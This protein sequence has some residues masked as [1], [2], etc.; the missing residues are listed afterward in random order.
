MY[1]V[2][3]TPDKQAL[4]DVMIMLCIRPA[5]IKNLRIANRGVT[6]YAKNWGQ[7]DIPWVFRSLEKNEERARQ[8]LTWIQ[9]AI[10][11][12][13]LKDLEKPGSTYLSS[14]LKKDEYI[15]KPYEPLLPSSLRKLGLVFAG[16]THMPKNLSK[17]NTYAREA[18]QHSSDNHVSSFDRYIIVNYKKWDQ[19]YD[20]ASP[21][22][23][24]NKN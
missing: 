15:P 17:F 18:L 20:Q 13:A 2:S 23:I 3:N 11:S 10:I 12:K 16:I 6:G 8:L 22:N 21:F 14:F 9:E 1:V 4:A 19:L 7:Q 24:F 5:E